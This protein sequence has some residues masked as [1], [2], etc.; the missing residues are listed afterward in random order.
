MAKKI[1]EKPHY[2]RKE[3]HI[4]LISL[5]SNCSD[6]INYISKFNRQLS[7]YRIM[8]VK[9]KHIKPIDI[10]QDMIISIENEQLNLSFGDIAVCVLSISH[11]ENR[12][13]EIK[14]VTDLAKTHNIKIFDSN[15]EFEIW[16]NQSFQN[17]LP[18]PN[19]LFNN[20]YIPED[21]KLHFT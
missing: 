9:Q 18:S 13:V 7:D 5:N 17:S 15:T 3:K 19:S 8:L 6:E 16:F 20:R 10:I 4:V 1:K 2:H 21:K 12:S 11:D 14:K